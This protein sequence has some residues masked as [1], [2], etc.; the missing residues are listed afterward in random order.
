MDRVRTSAMTAR[1]EAG[2]ITRDRSQ[3]FWLWSW[4]WIALSSARP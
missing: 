4:R 1:L 3:G 2:P